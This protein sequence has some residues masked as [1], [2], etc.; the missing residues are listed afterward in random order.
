MSPDR[1][2]ITRAEA[3]RR[4][5]EEQARRIEESAGKNSPSLL[6][7]LG[8]VA[9]HTTPAAPQNHNSQVAEPPA[10]YRTTPGARNRTANGGQP[11]TPPAN[12][13]PQ[14]QASQNGYAQ[15]NSPSGTPFSAWQPADQQPAQSPAPTARLRRVLNSNPAAQPRLRQKSA[16]LPA[17]RLPKVDLT[18]RWVA[19]AIAVVT[20]AAAYLLLYTPFFAVQRITVTGAVNV[21]STE[22]ISGMGVMQRQLVTLDWGQAR[23]ALLAGYPEIA[24]A[25]LQWAFPNTLA[26]TITERVPVAEWRQDNQAV[27]V[28]VDGFAFPVR[29]PA[30]GVT[31]VQANGPA[32]TPALT[33][34]QAA[35][36]GAKPFLYPELVR[37]IK[38][39][40]GTVPQG[41][42]L[43]YDPN[44]GLGWTDPQQGWQVFY[45]ST[46]GNNEEKMAVYNALVAELSAKGIR[47]TLINVEYPHAPFYQTGE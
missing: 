38:V 36:S 20:L 23:Q 25:R 27:W 40:S 37:A 12:S 41:T 34:E 2:T 42:V 8:N 7:K 28:D 16:P 17:L 18:S 22:L 9:K 26:V 14:A 10:P 3:L 15:H 39:V 46:E 35:L 21:N 31:V 13:A 4:R 29:N 19:L 44:Y 6:Q 11:A 33:E 1:T 5:K 45:G 47:P 32:P 24:D 43:M 30:L